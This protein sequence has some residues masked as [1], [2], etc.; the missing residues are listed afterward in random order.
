[1]RPITDQ[2]NVSRAKLAYLIDA[3]AAPV[4]II[5]PISSWAAAV[6]GFVPGEDGM[7][8]FVSAI[9]Y[10]YYALLT[11]VMMVSMV[12]MKVE[13]GAMGI[14]ESNAL[15]GDLFTTAARPYA[16]AEEDGQGESKR[17]S[18]GSS[19]SYYFPCYLLCYRNDLYRRIF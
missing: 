4:C 18:N 13:F 14:H 2:H 12:L 7:S 1:M 19:D 16:G 6:S 10:N 15:K 9:P 3:T 17:E 8:V 11:I 5:A